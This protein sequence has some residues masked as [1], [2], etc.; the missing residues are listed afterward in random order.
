MW[1]WQLLVADLLGVALLLN[2]KLGIKMKFKSRKDW[3]VGFIIFSVTL[4]TVGLV[5]YKIYI[6]NLERVD[7]WGLFFP[8]L[9][10]SYSLWIFYGTNYKLLD[11]KLIYKS[12]PTTGKIDIKRINEVEKGKTLWAGFRRPATA[13]HGLIIKY[14]KYEEI[15]I[16]PETNE[17]FI[18]CLLSIK[19]DIK[20]VN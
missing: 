17:A 8:L 1:C 9:V 10:A 13:R 15:Y 5:L 16:S 18:E 11:G 3:L 14:D 6:G 7:Y 2:G 4:Y 12:G 20:L 19:N